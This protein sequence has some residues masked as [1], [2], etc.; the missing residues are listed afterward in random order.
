MKHSRMLRGALIQILFL[1][2]NILVSEYLLCLYFMIF[3][4]FQ[5]KRVFYSAVEN[6][7]SDNL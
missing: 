7:Q 1:W 4:K 5:M 2:E 3:F 6:K